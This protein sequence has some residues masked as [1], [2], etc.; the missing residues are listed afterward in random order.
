MLGSPM[1][2]IGV[3]R[4]ILALNVIITVAAMTLAYRAL[5]R[6]DESERLVI[7][8]HKMLEAAEETLRRGVDVETWGGGHLPTRDPRESAPFPPPPQPARGA[9]GGPGP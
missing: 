1:K 6:A 2:S 5:H 4:V 9:M 7:R 3:L 8:S